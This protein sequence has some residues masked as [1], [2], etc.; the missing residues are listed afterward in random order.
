MNN[1]W[2]S[3]KDKYPPPHKNVWCL[4][5][6]GHMFEGR[7]CYG[8][9]EPFFTYPRG[10]GNASNTAPFWIKVTHWMPLPELPTENK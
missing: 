3:V 1:E 5:K 10:D 9:H 2:V 6:D 4:N 7:I 8:F